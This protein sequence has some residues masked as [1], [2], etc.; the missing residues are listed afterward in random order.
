MGM[1]LQG[2]MF[3]NDGTIVD[4]YDLIL[5]S[6][7]YATETV[8]GREFSDD[9]LMALVGTPLETQMAHFAKGDEALRVELTRVYRTHNHEHHDAMVSLYDGVAEGLAELKA[10]GLPLAVVT[11]KRHGLAQRG[12]EIVGVWQYFDF[13]IGTDDCE[14]SKPDPG[15]ILLGT[16]HMGLDPKDCMYVGDSPFDI[17]AGNAAGCTT[18]AA[19]WGMFSEEELSK[20]M[21]DYAC[22]SFLEFVELALRLM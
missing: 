10:H 1:A 21:P 15:P 8:L 12:L 11:S 7:H 6:M 13:L 5:S 17:K 3:D 18:M 22:A 14:T 2:I 4:T 16:Q 20:E 9:E 19:L